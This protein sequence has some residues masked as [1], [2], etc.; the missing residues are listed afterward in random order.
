MVSVIESIAIYRN[1]GKSQY[2][3]FS[4]SLHTQLSY[5]LSQLLTLT[6]YLCLW[7]FNR[8]QRKIGAYGVAT[9]P[10]TSR[11]M[12]TIIDHE[13]LHPSG[14]IYIRIFPTQCA[15]QRIKWKRKGGSHLDT[16]K[17]RIKDRPFAEGSRGCHV[18]L[19]LDAQSLSIEELRFI[20]PLGIRTFIMQSVAFITSISQDRIKLISSTLINHTYF[21]DFATW[22]LTWRILLNP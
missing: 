18:F 21:S 17:A 12:S 11:V 16:Y 6:Q 22:Q 19:W 13:N 20:L 9:Q 15:C 7:S 10:F 14:Y 3:S 4:A 1:I 5:S 8:T 2:K